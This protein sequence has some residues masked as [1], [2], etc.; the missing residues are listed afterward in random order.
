V[1][2]FGRELRSP[3][4]KAGV[5]DMDATAPNRPTRRP[6]GLQDRAVQGDASSDWWLALADKL[7]PKQVSA[8][9]RGALAGNLWQQWQLTRRMADSWPMFRK[10]CFELQAA[11][12]QCK[13]TVTPYSKPGAKPT[14][15]AIEKADLV[16]RA[17]DAFK[18]DRFAEEEGSAA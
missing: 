11:V 3:F 12:A 17:L 18:P 7:P 1:K 15:R 16:Q 10:C 4:V 9:L 14:P 8:I 6:E 13:V 5:A 2:L